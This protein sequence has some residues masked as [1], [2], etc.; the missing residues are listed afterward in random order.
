MSLVLECTHKHLHTVSY[1]KCIC[2]C[3]LHACTYTCMHTHSDT[4]MLYAPTHPHIHICMH[5]HSHKITKFITQCCVYTHKIISKV[6]IYLNKYKLT[7]LSTE[8][9]ALCI[10]VAN[11]LSL[12]HHQGYH[13][14]LTYI[15]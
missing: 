10:I 12:H 7:K 6:K 5:T 4:H 3:V 2:M 1:S 9:E 15:N 8:S 11:D 14:F 13:D